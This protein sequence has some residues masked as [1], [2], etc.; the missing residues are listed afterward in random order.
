M[1]VFVH[2][3]TKPGLTAAQVEQAWGA[4]SSQPVTAGASDLVLL[5]VNVFDEQGAPDAAF[6][7]HLPAVVNALKRVFGT[8]SVAELAPWEYE[9]LSNDVLVN[10]TVRKQGLVLTLKNGTVAAAAWPASLDPDSI[11]ETARAAAFTLDAAQAARGPVKT[12][13]WS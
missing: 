1:N 7:A 2:V 6:A 4:P 11:V 10:A 12:E 3:Q 13:V 5:S 9:L 8:D